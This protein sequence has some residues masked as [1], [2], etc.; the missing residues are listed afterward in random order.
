MCQSVF[1]I[2]FIIG[3][4]SPRMMSYPPIHPRLP[5]RSIPAPINVSPVVSIGR[6]R[7]HIPQT[8]LLVGRE[9]SRL[10]AGPGCLGRL[11]L[12]TM[13][14]LGK[15][16]TANL[17]QRRHSKGRTALP[18]L[19]VIV[20]GSTMSVKGEDSSSLHEEVTVA[21]ESL[22]FIVVADGHG[23]R[24][25]STYITT[26][27]VGRI[28]TATTGAG[29]AELDKAAK[30]AFRQIDKEVCEKGT[31][32][33]STCTVCCINSM[34]H[35][36]ST[37]NV[38]DSLA[39]MVYDGGYRE[40][41]QT[42]RLQDNHEEQERVLMKGARLGRAIDSNGLPGG[43]LRAYPGG[44]AVVRCIGDS[45][46]KQFVTA[47]PAFSTCQA[48]PQG[49]A[50]IACS[51]GVWEHLTAED[52][53]TC[54]LSGGYLGGAQAARQLVEA[55]IEKSPE[56][57]PTD[58]TSA[59]I[60][61]FGPKPE[62]G[63]IHEDHLAAQNPFVAARRPSGGTIDVGDSVQTHLKRRNSWRPEV[64]SPSDRSTR[65]T[66][67]SSPSE[68][69]SRFAGVSVKGGVAFANLSSLSS[70]GAKEVNSKNEIKP[71]RTELC[72]GSTGVLDIS[73][74]GKIPR[75]VEPRKMM[76]SPANLR[77]SLSPM[78]RRRNKQTDTENIVRSSSKGGTMKGGFSTMFDSILRTHSTSKELEGSK[79]RRS[80][81]GRSFGND[82]LTRSRTKMDRDILM[83]SGKRESLPW[84][85]RGV[86][87]DSFTSTAPD[88]QGWAPRRSALPGWQAYAD[89]SGPSLDH[90]GLPLPPPPMPMEDAD[91]G[92]SADDD[93]VDKYTRV[94]GSMPPARVIQWD[95]LNILK[96]LG[97][98]EFAMA[99]ATKI[100]NENVAVKMLK[101][102]KCEVASAVTGLKRKQAET[103]IDGRCITHPTPWHQPPLVRALSIRPL[104]LRSPGSC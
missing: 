93:L 86:N 99:Y 36:V 72:S 46:C 52:V 32:A 25:V 98:G 10:S 40:L 79:D 19:E 96:Y 75:S 100:E 39:M 66:P 60:L 94:H 61:V 68:I 74:S 62:S 42:H 85:A 8:G 84:Q 35:E 81:F 3:L 18:P 65:S 22:S 6:Q 28:V 4:A 97:Q 17:L 102:E 7:A 30:S 78:L 12:S 11:S 59:T 48:P 23:S 54:I 1:R 92:K 57:V 51:D 56:N 58:D 47:E 87:T 13:G 55:A 88:G 73:I 69:N 29:A 33:G 15:G 43:P 95:D 31:S 64:D 21:G 83:S 27:M 26:H 9:E 44:L 14:G 103:C 67:S 49:G 24:E 38:G 90:D 80:I 20:G 45:D 104:I 70:R 34:R 41:G 82:S 37:W 2:W 16:R 76:A 89:A 5:T 63:D 101:P 50:V 91:E 53:A 77:A 71:T